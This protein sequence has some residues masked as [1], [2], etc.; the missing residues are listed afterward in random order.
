MRSSVFHKPFIASLVLAVTG[1]ISQ[2]PVQSP[3]FARS[4]CSQRD[5]SP[6]MQFASDAGQG[7][8]ISEKNDDAP[9]VA[10][11]ARFIRGWPDHL[12]SLGLN[13]EEG[14]AVIPAVDAQALIRIINIDARIETISAPCL[15]SRSGVAAFMKVASQFAYLSAFEFRGTST[16]FMIDPVVDECEIGLFLSVCGRIEQGGVL[17]ETTD[18]RTCDLLGVRECSARVLQ[19]VPEGNRLSWSEPVLIKGSADLKTYGSIRLCKGDALVLPLSYCVVS[20]PSTTRALAA[21]GEGKEHYK[22]RFAGKGFGPMNR[23]VVL[24]L[25][26]DEAP[27]E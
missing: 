9:L 22:N 1:C 18:A 16:N 13:P 23:Q 17:V 14:I 27:R 19:G 6:L 7:S 21:D 8:A 25:F 11:R 12:S 26:A 20:E 10:I 3:G 24:M 4:S 15:T 2:D 5:L